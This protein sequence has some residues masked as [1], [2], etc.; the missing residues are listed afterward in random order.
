MPHRTDPVARLDD[1]LADLRH[2]I[3]NLLG[4]SLGFEQAESMGNSI[5]KIAL[6][7]LRPAGCGQWLERIGGI[8]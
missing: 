1:R 3:T 8:K 7:T 5:S 6:M 4:G 2:E